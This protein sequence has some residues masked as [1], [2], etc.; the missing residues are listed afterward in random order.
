MK[1]AASFLLASFALL[2]QAPKHC[3]VRT[4]QADARGVSALRGVVDSASHGEYRRSE[5][6]DCARWVIT[7]STCTLVYNGATKDE[8]YYVSKDGKN[9]I[10]GQTYDITR[11]PFA[12][13]S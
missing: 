11:S 13:Q 6:F 4:R 10:K 7:T 8:F 5:A 2:G 3:Q 12:E 1:I 9:I